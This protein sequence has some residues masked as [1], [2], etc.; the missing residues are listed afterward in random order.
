MRGGGTGPLSGRLTAAPRRRVPVR[1]ITWAN[2][3]RSVAVAITAAVVWFG[4][5]GT[6]LCEA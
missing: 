6:A 4:T 1:K 3:G 2:C 5:F